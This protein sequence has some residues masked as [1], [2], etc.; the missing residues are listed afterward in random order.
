MK[1]AALVTFFHN[2]TPRSG[3]NQ[4]YVTLSSGDLLYNVSTRCGSGRGNLLIERKE[5]ECLKLTNYTHVSR[6]FMRTV[7]NYPASYC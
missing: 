2:S 7:P 5:G 1:L 3:V 4:H 6:K